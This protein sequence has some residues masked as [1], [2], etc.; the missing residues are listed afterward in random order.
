MAA[1]HERPA[2][3][4]QHGSVPL[5]QPV[6]YRCCQSWTRFC[7]PSV[8]TLFATG[9][10]MPVSHMRLAQIPVRSIFRKAFESRLHLPT[11]PILPLCASRLHTIVIFKVRGKARA[12]CVQGRGGRRSEATSL[13]KIFR[14]RHWCGKSLSVSFWLR[15]SSLRFIAVSLGTALAQ[16]SGDEM[17][18]N[19]PG[20]SQSM[21]GMAGHGAG[22]FEHGVSLHD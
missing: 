15:S 1:L 7:N 16:D 8:F 4:H 10:L 11:R 13:R 19:M 17:K 3:C 18:M 5:P 22:S 9:L 21:P 12:N 14:R 2:G 20:D 6:S